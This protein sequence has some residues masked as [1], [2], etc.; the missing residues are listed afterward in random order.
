ME[1]LLYK[2]ATPHLFSKN[3][4]FARWKMCLAVATKWEDARE[5][6]VKLSE[7]YHQKRNFSWLLSEELFPYRMKSDKFLEKRQSFYQ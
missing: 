6:F 5:I 4:W 1:G 2:A 3:F 7:R